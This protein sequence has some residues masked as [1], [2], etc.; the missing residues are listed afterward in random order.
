MI[1]KPVNSLALNLSNFIFSSQQS[2]YLWNCCICDA[3]LSRESDLWFNLF[4]EKDSF[5][6]FFFFPCPFPAGT[7]HSF[8]FWLKPSYFLLSCSWF[9]VPHLN[10]L[11]ICSSDEISRCFFSQAQPAHVSAVSKRAICQKH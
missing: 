11:T 2:Q 8:H 9:T 10:L 3:F 7:F 1:I 5:F 4:Q 6:F